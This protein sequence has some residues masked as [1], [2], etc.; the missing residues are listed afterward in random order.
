[1]I[2]S[3]KGFDPFDSI[4]RKQNRAMPW[5]PSYLYSYI[6]S[7]LSHSFSMPQVPNQFL[8]MSK[9]N[10]YIQNTIKQSLYHHIPHS[11]RSNNEK[12]FTSFEDAKNHDENR[13]NKEQIYPSDP[14]SSE[15]SKDDSSDIDKLSTDYTLDSQPSAEE[16]ESE[17]AE[18]IA[19]SQQE[20][21]SALG[22]V[23]TESF[24][25]NEK[26]KSGT[27]SKTIGIQPEVVET[28]DF[29]VIKI[30]IPEGVSDS[31]LRISVNERHASI[32]WEPG[33]MEQV[34]KLPSDIIKEEA[35]AAVKD[36]ILEIKVPRFNTNKA[37][38]IDIYKS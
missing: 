17:P 25:S 9:L 16:S 2:D 11:F 34:V 32:K 7:I 15:L 37:K 5:D 27:L 3:N 6:T 12:H 28:H 38:R 10:E 13:E 35:T 26:P 31:G 4:N 22:G 21:G 19:K 14:E 30:K 29:I 20:E 1:M 33:Y 23:N 36:D 18:D 8:D 24:R